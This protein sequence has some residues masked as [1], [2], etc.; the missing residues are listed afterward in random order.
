M[1]VLADLGGDLTQAIKFVCGNQFAFLGVHFAPL[2]LEARAVLDQSVIDGLA[3]DVPQ[4]TRAMFNVL[5]DR[6]LP[7]RLSRARLICPAV[8]VCRR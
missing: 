3:V 7:A 6:P 5:G 1:T 2:D 8:I 4:N